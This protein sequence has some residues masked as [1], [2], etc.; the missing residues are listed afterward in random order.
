MTTMWTRGML[1][2][3][4]KAV[5]K[6]CYWK[7]LLISLVLIIAGGD[8][9]SGNISWRASS[10][11]PRNPGDFFNIF[12][13]EAHFFYNAVIIMIVVILVFLAYRIFIGYSLE[14]GGRRFFKRA[15]ENDI[16]TRHMG[17]A[18]GR[19]RYMSIVKTMFYKGVL[20][21]L[22]YLLLIIPGIVKGYAYS[23]VPYILT[24]NPD[25]GRERAVELSMQMTDGHKFNMWILDWSFLG[26]YL[27]G[28]LLLVVGAVLVKPYENAT[29][30]ELY[31]VLRQNALENGFCS[32]EELQ[33]D[34]ALQT[35]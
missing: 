22:W 6:L 30:A 15:A 4:A 29:K 1:K 31:L 27:L 19:D 26:W 2:T 32:Y 8:S 20:N 5:L 24:D 7:A 12:G 23:M 18:F 34:P 14:V 35:V 9:N 25:I 16:E 13:G 3:R 28:L 33:L 21:F 10:D 17:Y 11:H